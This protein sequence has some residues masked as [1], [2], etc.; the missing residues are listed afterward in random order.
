MSSSVLPQPLAAPTDNGA[1]PTNAAAPPPA[2]SRRE[3]R[4]AAHTPR[5]PLTLATERTTLFTGETLNGLLFPLPLA[6]S[7]L[8]LRGRGPLAAGT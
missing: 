7:Q 4:D 5:S 1:T 6:N 8:N 2:T 3:A